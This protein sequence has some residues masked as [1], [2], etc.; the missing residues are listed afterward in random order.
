MELAQRV[1]DVRNRQTLQRD[2]KIK[3]IHTQLLTVHTLLSYFKYESFIDF[4]RNTEV[5]VARRALVR[6]VHP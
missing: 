2:H 6:L 1:S 5:R 4:A 3:V